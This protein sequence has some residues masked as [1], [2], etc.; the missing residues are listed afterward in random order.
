MSQ[1]ASSSIIPII[2]W[3][4][5]IWIFLYECWLGYRAHLSNEWPAVKAKILEASIE[6]THGRTR[7]TRFKP[8]IRYE[9]RVGPEVFEC[10]RIAFRTITYSYLSKN[11][12]MEDFIVGDDIVVF[13]DPKNPGSAVIKKGI[14][15]G[16]ILGPFV[17]LGL[18]L[19]F[20]WKTH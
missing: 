3:A 14:A 16:N 8:K 9:Y 11:K 6:E 10:G 13:Y 20:Y 18:L 5:L 4:V 2:V 17:L 12:A 15:R 1:G 7:G 19:I